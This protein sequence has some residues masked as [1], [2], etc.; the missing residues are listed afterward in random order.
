MEIEQEEIRSSK[1]RMDKRGN[2]G[3]KKLKG[4][5]KIRERKRERKNFSNFVREIEDDSIPLVKSSSKNDS[6]FK[7]MISQKI[8]DKAINA[9]SLGKQLGLRAPDEEM[10]ANM[11][12]LKMWAKVQS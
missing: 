11:A 3:K 12:L 4:K 5:G 8:R 2:D 6:G 1:K 9:W 7:D 10:I